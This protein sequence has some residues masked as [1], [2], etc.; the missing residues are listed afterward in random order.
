LETHL[1]SETVVDF[2]RIILNWILEFGSEGANGYQ[3][4]PDA[5]L[6]VTILVLQ[7]SEAV[8]AVVAVTR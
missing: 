7:A 8:S 1:N 6:S 4:V 5:M 3:S 2:V